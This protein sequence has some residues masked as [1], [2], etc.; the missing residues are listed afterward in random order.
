MF[1]YSSLIAMF[2]RLPCSSEK[3]YWHLIWRGANRHFGDALVNQTA[4]HK[5]EFHR[6]PSGRLHS[7]SGEFHPFSH[8]ES[9]GESSG[10]HSGSFI[11]DIVRR[12]SGVSSKIHLE[13]SQPEQHAGSFVLGAS[14]SASTG[15]HL[16][17][18]RES[19]QPE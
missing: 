12:S 19:S 2:H 16:E 15:D 4:V 9:F 18:H 7:S 8:S 3:L 10:V 13:S 1:P 6:G 17:S 14:S 11:Q 5:R